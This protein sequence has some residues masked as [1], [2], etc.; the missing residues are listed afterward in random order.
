MAFKS[1]G[2]ISPVNCHTVAAHLNHLDSCENDSEY[3]VD[4]LHPAALPETTSVSVSNGG[5]GVGESNPAV[6]VS[7]VTVCSIQL[8]DHQLPEDIRQHQQRRKT[9]SLIFSLVS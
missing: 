6:V 5:G 9:Y 2:Y 3:M 4:D 1:S 7:G 8:L